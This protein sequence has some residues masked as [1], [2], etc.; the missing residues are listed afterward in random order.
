MT[1]VPRRRPNVNQDFDGP[2]HPR[3]GSPE[4]L[5]EIRALRRELNEFFSVYLN[6]RFPHGKPNDTWRRR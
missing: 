5:K 1:T 4:V 3:L 6:A 2:A